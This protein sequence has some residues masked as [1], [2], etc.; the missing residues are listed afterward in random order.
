MTQPRVEFEYVWK[1][2]RRGIKHDSLRDLVPAAARSL[3]GERQPR[4][5]LESNEFWALRDVSFEVPPGSTLGIIGPNGA[6]KSTVLKLLIGILRPNR[7][8][9][10][11]E[12]RTGALI[13]IAAGFHQDLSGREN[14]FLQG[15]IMGMKRAEIARQFDRIVEFSELSEFIDTQVKRYSSGMN[16]RLGFAIAA[17]LDPEVLI[18]DE[19]LA[20]GDRAFQRKAFERLAE[21]AGRDIPVVIVSHQLDRVASLCSEAI[22][23]DHGR[24]VMA[25]SASECI[26]RYVSG[27]IGEQV[28]TGPPGA[29]RL[30]QLRIEPDVPVHPGDAVRVLLDAEAL[31]PL[32]DSETLL[33]RVRRVTTGELLFSL[34]TRA[35]DQKLPSSGRFQLALELRAHLAGGMYLV[36]VCF[37]DLDTLRDTSANL[38]QTFQVREDHNFHGSV[39]LDARFELAPAPLDA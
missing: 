2:F 28:R 38:R 6:G 35:A 9:A 21:I 29:I 12:G 16:A 23:L 39:N 31:A 4:P 18:I 14:V 3:F 24:V 36:E 19:V 37:S 1:K 7:G 22:L 10:R 34:S 32:P 26:A 8:S 17:H 27:G 11:V 15:A 20:V 33:V 30:D 13:E 5:A 25:G